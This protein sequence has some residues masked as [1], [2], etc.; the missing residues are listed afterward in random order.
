MRI[1]YFF[2]NEPHRYKPMRS[3][4]V[5]IRQYPKYGLIPTHNKHL[6]FHR[7]GH[8]YDVEIIKIRLSV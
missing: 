5:L 7:V 1:K 6:V 8:F 3:W 2:L 4:S